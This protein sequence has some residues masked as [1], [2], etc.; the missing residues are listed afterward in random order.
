MGPFTDGGKRMGPDLRL[1]SHDTW[2]CAGSLGQHLK[3]PLLP[4][5]CESKWTL[6]LV[7]R[8]T[9]R[10]AFA[11]GTF[12]EP[13][14]RSL[15]RWQYW[16]RLHGL[17][18]L[19]C[20]ILSSPWSSLWAFC[21]LGLYMCHMELNQNCS[22]WPQSQQHQIQATPSTYTTAHSNTRVTIYTIYN[23]M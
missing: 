15:R 10:K 5:P 9:L 7:A 17:E 23:I 8:A 18:A 13:R 19:P 21:F 20:S 3:G 1:P 14:P 6:W 16:A 2:G 12:L 11:Q 22:W 4:L